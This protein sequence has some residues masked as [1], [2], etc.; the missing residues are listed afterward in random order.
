M[1]G[2]Q[3]IGSP[4]LWRC[5]ELAA[6]ALSR[7]A[8]RSFVRSQGTVDQVGNG[9]AHMISPVADITRR[10]D[11]RMRSILL[12]ALVAAG[13]GLVGTAG[14]SAAPINGAAIGNAASDTSPVTTVQHW[15][16]GS[17]GGG[18]WRWG[19]RGG[20]HWRWGS[21]GPGRRC[22]RPWNSRWW[23]C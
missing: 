21:R 20:G 1:L 22:H 13:V 4:M 6:Y 12:A 5:N 9:A 3:S 17:G 7:V 15:R 19:S 11:F 14:V 23:F 18:H 10:G 8:E 2:L 16:W